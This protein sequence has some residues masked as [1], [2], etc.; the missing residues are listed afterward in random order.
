MK[1]HLCRLQPLT[2]EQWL[3]M[4]DSAHR[5]STSLP[6]ILDHVRKAVS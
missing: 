2:R 3:A 1:Q 5:L 6:V 4:Q